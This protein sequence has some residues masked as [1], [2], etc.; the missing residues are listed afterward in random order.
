MEGSLETATGSPG[1]MVLTGDLGIFEVE[2]L[3][4]DLCRRLES[5]LSVEAVADGLIGLDTSIVQLLMA[6]KHAWADRNLT[7]SITG[8]PE[9][10]RRQ[11]AMLDAR[12]VLD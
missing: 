4:R 12:T 6:A 11:L 3:H 10:V 2:A 5:G 7:F 8:C 1:R 9:S